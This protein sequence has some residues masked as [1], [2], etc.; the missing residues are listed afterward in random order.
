MPSQL[1]SR[2]R[3]AVTGQHLNPDHDVA[4][5]VILGV[6]T[7]KDIHVGAVI[8]SLGV[9]LGSRDFPATAAGYRRLL[10]WARAH[11]PIRRAGVE[12]TASYGAA[13]ARMLRGAGIKVIE[14]NQ[15]DRASRRR[16]GKTDA[17]D[18]EAA[19]RAVLSGRAAA[20]A[21]SGDGP[22][23]ITRMLKLAKTSAVKSRTQAINQ[24]K[25]VLVGADAALRE[26]MAGLS[27][28]RLVKACT[29]LDDDAAAS[30][31]TRTTRY[32]LRLLARRITSSP[33]R[34]ATL[35]PG[36]PP[37]SAS[38]PPSCSPVTA[39]A[40]TQPLRCSSPPA[41]IPAG[42]TPRPRSRRCAGSARSKPLLARPSACAST[43]VATGRQT[44][45]C[46]ASPCPACDG[47]RP[48]ATTP[49][50]ASV[51][52]RPAVRRSAASSATSPG[53]STH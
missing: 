8:S 44:P 32:T 23:E 2:Q 6:D 28:P 20:V 15:P 29:L 25:A 49:N 24:L 35:T 11:G 53:N 40:P 4:G 48:P 46:T 19:A 10:A 41:T 16:R 12:G 38:T 47:I 36:W 13:L 30:D 5:E 26:S 27:T 39:S 51:T 21:K 52:A 22:V 3:P 43:A 31:V 45:P 33:G 9:L 50:G 17:I 34:S 1:P 14:V 42:C 37:P 7:H 18:A